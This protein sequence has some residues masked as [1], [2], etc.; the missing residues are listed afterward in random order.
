MPTNLEKHIVARNVSR[1][2]PF[3]PQAAI[4]IMSQIALG[5]DYLHRQGVVHRDLKPNNILVSPNPNPELCDEGYVEVKLA[6][7][8]L[9][10]TKVNTSASMLHAQICEA[11]SWRALEADVYG[12][13]Y[14]HTLT[15]S[16]W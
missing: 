14:N 12:C 11:T 10:K 13:T 2:Y 15:N 7:F 16:L 1:E 5:V 9:A 3:M 8:G 6:D 4:D